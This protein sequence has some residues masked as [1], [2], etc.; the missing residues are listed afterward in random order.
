M[1][2]VLAH[3]D[4]PHGNNFYLSFTYD[5]MLKQVAEYCKENWKTYFNEEFGNVTEIPASDKEIIEMFFKEENAGNLEFLNV[6]Y[7]EI[8]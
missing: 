5:G 1:E 3:I 7:I 2:V 4:H 8:L 6:E